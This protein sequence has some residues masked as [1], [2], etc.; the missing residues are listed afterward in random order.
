MR[1]LID[2][3]LTYSNTN[4]VDDTCAPPKLIGE[5]STGQSS[6][7]FIDPFREGIAFHSIDAYRLDYQKH[8]KACFE[9][10]TQCD[11]FIYTVG[12][13]ESWIDD[14]SGYAYSHNAGKVFRHRSTPKMVS[15]ENNIKAF[16]YFYKNFKEL[17]PSATIILTVSPLPINACV[18]MPCVFA[19]NQVSKSILRA[20]VHEITSS[21]LFPQV[22]Y[23]PSFELVLSCIK[24]PFTA[25]TRH[26]KKEVAENIFQH[27]VGSY[28]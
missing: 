2:R 22:E 20:A 19:A 4:R 18:T 27:F 28:Y 14:D 24:D 15:L 23:F 17:N 11:L 1:Y 7:V 6:C 10:L 16:S 21:G 25:N 9:A 5:F 13:N 26:V 8:S 3:A 12:V